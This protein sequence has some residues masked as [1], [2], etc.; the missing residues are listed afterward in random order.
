MT[1]VLDV[2]SL[3]RLVAG[4]ALLRDVSLRLLPGEIL[5]LRGPSGCGK[6]TLLRCLARLDAV[7]SGEIRLVGTPG[8]QVPVR[9]WRRRV[10]HLFQAPTPLPGSL[11]ENL[12]YGPL[13]RGL[14]PEEDELLGRLEAVGLGGKAG[15][16]AST[17]SGGELQRLALARVL[18]N[19][20]Q[21]LLLDEPTSALDEASR[22]GVEACV[23]E[24]VKREGLACL[25]TTHD[26]S[27]AE[28]VATRIASMDAGRLVEEPGP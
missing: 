1:P 2:R 18:A 4:K 17:L 14:V 6:S 9:D 8:G 13:L 23:T 11:I 10:G 27:Q 16:E 15:Q 24:S 21:V 3:S 25:W 7:D 5:V 20:P 19:R 28:R 22:A 12:R 26:P